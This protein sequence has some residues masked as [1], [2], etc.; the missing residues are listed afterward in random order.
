VEL[1]RNVLRHTAASY[2]CAYL[3]S[4]SAAAL[5]LGHSE[6]MLIKHYR[7][8]V[9]HSEGER[10]FTLP[11]PEQLRSFTARKPVKRKAAA[12]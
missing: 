3:E 7:A 2:L 1:P 4:M 9:P 10:F 6:S 8:L 12:H 5:N 11:I